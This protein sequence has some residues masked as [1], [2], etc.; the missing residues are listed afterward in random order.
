MESKNIRNRGNDG[1]KRKSKTR[2]NRSRKHENRLN[3]S[4]YQTNL[5]NRKKTEKKETVMNGKSANH[6]K[7]S[8]PS[9]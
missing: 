6:D 3:L 1:V 4:C 5:L 2:L 7:A 9:L 8:S